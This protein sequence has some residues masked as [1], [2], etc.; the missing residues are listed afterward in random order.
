MTISPIIE[1][2]NNLLLDEDYIKFEE[3]YKNE[4]IIDKDLLIKLL[5]KHHDLYYT[6]LKINLFIYRFDIKGLNSDLKDFKRYKGK[7]YYIDDL[8]YVL[9]FYY[10]N[11]TRNQS[12]FKMMIKDKLVPLKERKLLEMIM[13]NPM[14]EQIK[15]TFDYEVSDV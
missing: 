15:P 1:L 14:E 3:I 11:Y 7:V 8:D 13:N 4:N 12:V 2:N 9:K 5:D 6:F 10:S